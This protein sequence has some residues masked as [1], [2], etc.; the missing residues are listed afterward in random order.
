[1]KIDATDIAAYLII[2]GCFTLLILNIDGEVKSILALAA[3]WAFRKPVVN[4]AS[5]VGKK[6]KKLNNNKGD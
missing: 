3:G 2:V 6:L 1:M 5:S 4:A